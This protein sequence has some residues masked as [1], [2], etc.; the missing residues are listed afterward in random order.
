MQKANICASTERPL[1]NRKKRTISV[2]INEFWS[3]ASVLSTDVGSQRYL[4]YE[5]YIPWFLTEIP[6]Y[7]FFKLSFCQFNDIIIAISILCHQL[8]MQT[9]FASSIFSSKV[10]ANR[11]QWIFLVLCTF[12]IALENTQCTQNIVCNY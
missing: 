2:Q 11:K 9:I 7:F 12:E 4:I 1:E 3:F 10:Q 8:I 5:I 6:R